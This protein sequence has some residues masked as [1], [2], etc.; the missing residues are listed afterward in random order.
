[1]QALTEELLGV[2]ERYLCSFFK[3]KISYNVFGLKD[4]GVILKNNVRGL[5]HRIY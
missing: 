3:T 4:L 2:A 5:E 1:M